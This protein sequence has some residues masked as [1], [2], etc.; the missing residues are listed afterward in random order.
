MVMGGVLFK[1]LLRDL[2]SHKVSIV[3]IIL[4]VMIGV[5]GLVMMASLYRD[6]V[7]ARDVYYREKRL[8]D[9]QIDMKRAPESVVAYAASLPNVRETYGRVSLPA[10]LDLPNQSEPISGTVISLPERP[11][12]ILND[13]FLKTGSW[14]SG[15]DNKEAILNDSFAEA[16][17]LKPGDRLRVLL[18]DEQ[19]EVLIV[20]TARS[21]EFVYLIPMDGGLAPDPARFG[22][23]YMEEQFLQRAGDLDG[24][25]NQI[26]GMA[27]DKGATPI[28]NTLRLIEDKLDAWGVTNA[29]QMK[30]QG[31]VS[32]L[33]N[34][35]QGLRV[36]SKIMPSIFLSV[37][38]LIL[39]VLMSRIVAHQRTTIGTLKA[40]GRSN[41]QISLHYIGFGAVIGVLGGVAGAVFAHY[42]QGVMIKLYSQ[43]YLLPDLR[44]HFY[45]EFHLL[46]LVV[47]VLFASLGTI[48]GVRQ[49]ARLQPADAMRPPPPER[50][51]RIWLERIDFLWSRLSFKWRLVA[52]AIFRNPFRSMTSLFTAFVATALIITQFCMID[53]LNYLMDYTFK[54]LAHQDVTI[55]IREPVGPREIGELR[56]L[57]GVSSIEPQLN[58]V[59]DLVN[60]PRTKRTAVTGIPP[61]NVLFTPLDE[62]GNPIVIPPQGLV[63]SKKL[64]EILGVSVGDSLKLRPLIARRET[65][66][67]PVVAI[68]ETFMGTS[69]YADIRYLSGLIG[70]E[71]VANTVLGE[72]FG[73]GQ[74]EGMNRE[75][76]EQRSI[77]GISRRDRALIQTQKTFGDAQ[78]VALKIMILFAGL[79]AFGSVLNNAFVSLSE[80]EREV[81]IFR[82][83]GYT[84][85]EIAAILRGELV[86]LSAIGILFGYAGGIALVNVISL[87]F[88]TD[89]FRFPVVI[90]PSR[91]VEGTLYMIFFI[92]IAQVIVWR[93][94]RG[95]DWLEATKI[96]E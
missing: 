5:G 60:G 62:Q 95:F 35:L 28:D 82:V 34:E 67:A 92:G 19:H 1:K 58:V 29:T 53:A 47:S 84:P 66:Q 76:K 52:R 18:L 68:V 16:N 36:Q 11:R 39:N 70:E 64:A 9:F 88:N 37:A 61:G 51:R 26:L 63:M 45:P 22:V 15:R 27:H 46:G 87:A 40:L 96:K 41:T 32:F 81:G 94:I 44:P 24:A 54:Q 14:F 89:L 7:G 49:A 21:P 20:G 30:D 4:I 3:I 13:V 77:I 85:G 50:G 12:P 23:I 33:D 8:A 75:L 55:N 86:I 57:R 91:L 93:Y 74:W 79:I 65:V 90:Y 2:W 83:L 59:C 42:M 31:S 38:L 78:S 72:D 69:A 73:A 56:K 80:R 6:L 48:H 10:L 25:Y 71:Q 43:F 17:G